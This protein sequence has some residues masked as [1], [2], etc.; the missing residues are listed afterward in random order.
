MVGFGLFD[1]TT[2]D[3]GSGPALFAGGDFSS[4]PDS[5]DANIAK[6]GGC[7]AAPPIW[8]DLGFGLAGVAGVP[9]LSGFGKLLAGSSGSLQLVDAAPLAPALLVL[10]TF[11]TP[12]PF[13]GGTLVP[14]P[15]LFSPLLATD[16]QGDQ[17]VPWTA[18]PS[19]LSGLS[20]FFQCAIHD[21]V[22]VKG[23]ALSNALRGDVP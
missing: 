14:V 9:Q 12:T 2:F 6:W 1:L 4:A 16:L 8:T 5:G 20:L 23:V 21:G 22:A 17:S 11:G 10:S 7:P 15:I 18:A 19:G 3:D 13:K